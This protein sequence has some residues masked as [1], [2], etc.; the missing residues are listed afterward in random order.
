M[1]LVTF[2]DSV[3][4]LDSEQDDRLEGLKQTPGL[5]YTWHMFTHY[6]D[7]TDIYSHDR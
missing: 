3:G 5:I 7:K 6:D 2:T 1:S 4:A